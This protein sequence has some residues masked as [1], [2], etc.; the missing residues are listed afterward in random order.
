MSKLTRKAERAGGQQQVIDGYWV[1]RPVRPFD[2]H[3]H[4]EEAQ[5]T[6]AFEKRL[7]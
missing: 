4:K 1:K 2:E 7:A 5:R 6:L 3:I